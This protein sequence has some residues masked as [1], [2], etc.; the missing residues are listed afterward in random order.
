MTTTISTVA[1]ARAAKVLAKAMPST[2]LP[3]G[4]QLEAWVLL[5]LGGALK[6]LGASVHA[7]PSGYFYVRLNQHK[8]FKSPRSSWLEITYDGCEYELHNA[9]QI[10]GRSRAHHEIDVCLVAGKPKTAPAHRRIFRAGIECKQHT[11]AVS[12]NVV[13]A[14][15]GISLEVN[16]FWLGHCFPLGV[17]STGGHI[18]KNTER[19]LDY[20]G[21]AYIGTDVAN[22][23]HSNFAIH[24]FANRI[25]R[26]L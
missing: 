10:Q 3:I 8:I 16:Q 15:L 5:T 19:L 13:R 4:P 22:L 7:V 24:Q 17:A 12:E 6:R 25:L 21:I 26:S 2:T 23:K 14:L 20:Y 9:L 18:S 11:A 1:L